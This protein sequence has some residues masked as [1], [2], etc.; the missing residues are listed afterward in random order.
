MSKVF[1]QNTRASSVGLVRANPEYPTVPFEHVFPPGVSV[2]AADELE[3]YLANAI[4]ERLFG[5]GGVLKV[6]DRM[7]A[8]HGSHADVAAEIQSCDDSAQL[9]HWLMN[10]QRGATHRAE[11]IARHRELNPSEDGRPEAP[12]EGSWV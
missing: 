9:R 4:N 8:E 1:V 5:K 10:T 12:A 2:I 11:L 3:L 6:V 7:P